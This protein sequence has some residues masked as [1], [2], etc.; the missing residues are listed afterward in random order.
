[1]IMG[2]GNTVGLFSALLFG[3]YFDKK[4]SS[5]VRILIKIDFMG[6]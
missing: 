2:I 1:M 5:N 6:N 3:F 4:K